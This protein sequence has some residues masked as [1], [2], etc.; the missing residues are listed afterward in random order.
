MMYVQQ[1]LDGKNCRDIERKYGIDHA[2]V[3]SW[4][5]KYFLVVRMNLDLIKRLMLVDFNVKT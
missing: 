2:V 1:L 5:N 4:L 3:H